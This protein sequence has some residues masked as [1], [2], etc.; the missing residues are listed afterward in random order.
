MIDYRQLQAFATVL[1]V[2]SFDKAAQKLFITQSAISQRI[3]QL[4]ETLGQ[5]LIIRGQPPQATESGQKLLR[6]YQQVSL[7]QNDLFRQLGSDGS[8]AQTRLTIGLNADTLATWFFDALQP[9]LEPHNIILEL[10]VDDQEQTHKLLRQ[11]MVIGCISASDQAI[12]GGN[13]IPLGICRYRALA[14]PAFIRRYFADGVNAT[15]LQQAPLVEYNQKDELQLQYL[16]RYYPDCIKPA[17][18]RIPSTES[19]MEFIA[20]GYGWGM[21]P[22]QQSRAL[23]EQHRLT[24]LEAEQ[25]LDIPLY[26]HSWNL[27]GEVVRRLTDTLSRFCRTALLPLAE[28]N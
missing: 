12:Q 22:D 18:H 8:S 24:E 17:G 27:S 28:K 14:S 10:H 21:V 4:E 6:H 1:E 15:A 19:F 7:L 11:G 20:R 5:V 9:L 13:C 25:P 23:R 16:Q 26:W 2:Q 3:K